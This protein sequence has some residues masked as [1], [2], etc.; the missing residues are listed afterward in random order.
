MT[1]KAFDRGDIVHLDFDPTKGKEQRGK[2]F[3]LVLSPKAFNV[4][5]LTFVAPITQGGNEARFKG[6]AVSLMGTGLKTQGVVLVN[7]MRSMDLSVRNAK[8]IEPVPEEIIN[9]CLYRL[10]AIIEP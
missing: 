4:A 10:Q 2:R 6:F 3:G 7:M 8:R 1:G 9:D 5:G